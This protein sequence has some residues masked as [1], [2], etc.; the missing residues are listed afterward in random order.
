MRA[1]S[2][3]LAS[4]LIAPARAD[5]SLVQFAPSRYPDAVCTDG[6]PGGYY[7]KRATSSSSSHLWLVYLQGGGWC[8]DAASCQHR[9]GTPQSP[10]TSALCSSR[11]WEPS[12][13]LFGVFY[14][15]SDDVLKKANKVYVRY[16][17]SDAHMGNRGASSATAG[18]HFRGQA[19]VQATLAELVRVHGLGS[20]SGHQVVFGGGSAGGR[21]AMVHLDYVAQM[22][23]PAAAANMDVV[24]FLDSPLWLDIAPMPGV[25][26]PGFRAVTQKV[27]AWANVSHFGTNCSARYQGSDQW[28]CMFGQ[29]R[30]PTLTTPYFLVAS[31]YDSFQLGN[32]VG[33]EPNAPAELQYAQTFADQTK[34][35]VLALVSN[36]P[37]GGRQIGAF[38]WACYSHSISTSDNGYNK[39]TSVGATMGSAFKHVRPGV[40]GQWVEDCRGFACGE[41]CSSGGR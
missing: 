29:Y 25:S 31:Q 4:A 3:L 9:C 17:T 22:A 20:S 24:G 15:R 8:Y 19:M 41:G 7:W 10:S 6:S 39:Y 5:L 2:L 27:H 14:P 30:I 11:Q 16:C 36:W 21:G 34:A 32:N 28:K 18:W 38:S 13:P 40:T 33:R 23:G 1:V 26:F 12:L 37:R 35:T